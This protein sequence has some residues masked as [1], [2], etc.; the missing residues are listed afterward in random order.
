MMGSAVSDCQRITQVV[1]GRSWLC[2]AV[3][4][5]CTACTGLDHRI[6]QHQETFQSL[7][8]TA[9]TIGAAWLA[10]H[11]SAT[12]TGTA[13]E[14]TF[15]LI[16]QERTSL[17]SQPEML[18]DSRGAALADHADELAR[19]VAQLIKDVRGSDAAAARDHLAALPIS[20][21][22]KSQ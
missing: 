16:E 21:E 12:Y 17:A 11:L 18:T 14:Q 4:L 15:L 9:H 3:A 7:T 10:G 5:T 20:Q 22:R 19:L 13:L 8:S 2:L 6:Q 1:Q